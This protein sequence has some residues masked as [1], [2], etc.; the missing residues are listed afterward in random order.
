MRFDGRLSSGAGEIDTAR[1]RAVDADADF[2]E[3]GDCRA[4]IDGVPARPI[5]P[6][7]DRDIAL[8]RLVSEPGEAFPP[9]DGH[10]A[11]CGFRVPGD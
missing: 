7:R 4:D 6:G 2:P 3:P 1:G 9:R 11:G 10:G 5:K 8:F